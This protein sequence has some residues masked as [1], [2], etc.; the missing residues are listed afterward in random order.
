MFIMKAGWVTKDALT[1]LDVRDAGLHLTSF[2]HGQIS[3]LCFLISGINVN[4]YSEE[5]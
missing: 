3:T 4:V 1:T 5:A 2:I